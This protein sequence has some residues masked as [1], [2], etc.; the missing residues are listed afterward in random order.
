VQVKTF[1]QGKSI[2]Y[3]T[4][5]SKCFNGVKMKLTGSYNSGIN[6]IRDCWLLHV[7]IING[8]PD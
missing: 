3:F 8:K 4:Q 6:M 7:K 5:F 1:E 2:R